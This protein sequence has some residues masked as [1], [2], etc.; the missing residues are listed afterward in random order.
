MHIV[1][2]KLQSCQ[3]W[4]RPPHGRKFF[5]QRIRNTVEHDFRH[6]V[7]LVECS[8]DVFGTLVWRTRSE[9]LY[10]DGERWPVIQH[11]FHRSSVSTKQIQT[12]V[13]W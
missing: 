6:P 2:R 9:G 5:K 13:T 7:M 11:F 4:E 1:C 3:F 10:G 8:D 12:H